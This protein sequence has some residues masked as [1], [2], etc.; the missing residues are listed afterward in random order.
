MPTTRS[1]RNSVEV[2]NQSSPSHDN[3][4]QL[5]LNAQN[6]SLPRSDTCLACKEEF[7][8]WFQNGL[9]M[10]VSCPC[11]LSVCKH[12]AEKSKND[13]EY[14]PV[15]AHLD[16]RDFFEK[17]FKLQK[18]QNIN[19]EELAVIDKIPFTFRNKSMIYHS[20][21]RSEEEFLRIPESKSM[22]HLGQSLTK[23]GRILECSSDFTNI[24]IHNINIYNININIYNIYSSEDIF[25]DKSFD[26]PKQHSKKMIPEKDTF[27]PPHA[28]FLKQKMVFGGVIILGVVIALL[29][30][31][32]MRT[33]TTSSITDES[34]MIE[35]V[36][37]QV[38]T[39]ENKYTKQPRDLWGTLRRGMRNLVKK[40]NEP[41]TILL[42]HSENTTVD[43]CFL[44]D[45]KKIAN[46][47]V[48]YQMRLKGDESNGVTATDTN[49]VVTKPKPNGVIIDMETNSDIFD[50]PGVF[51]ETYKT[52]LEQEKLMIVVNFHKSPRMVMEA[53]HFLT[54]AFDP[55]VS[56]IL[57]ILTVE[58]KN[59][60]YDAKKN[61]EYIA[62]HELADVLKGLPDHKSEPLITR[63]TENV[64]M[65]TEERNMFSMSCSLS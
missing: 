46:E 10:A 2:T 31:Y 24:N 21:P 23:D 7:E 25:I 36:F 55:Y 41:M 65:I 62:E 5:D 1:A 12:C 19:K 44:R 45:I 58:V 18:L 8:V 49:E 6:K 26:T 27:P 13:E 39:L 32:L 40:S 17:E 38:H 14:C 64:Y 56:N 3:E 9:D 37:E 35:H 30:G 51:M 42:L 50:N 54:D 52:Q 61:V 28:S 22:T 4:S 53:F 34:V 47:V 59:K 15:D 20:K 63:L 48:E 11:I 57:I 60:N 43:T 16:E 33:S 29:Y